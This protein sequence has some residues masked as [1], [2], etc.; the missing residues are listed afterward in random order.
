VQALQVQAQVCVR[1]CVCLLSTTSAYDIS[2]A[3]Q[4]GI[5]TF[6]F[7][8]CR[9]LSAKEPLII[10]LFCEKQPAKMRPPMS[11]SKAIQSGVDA[12]V[13]YVKLQVSFRQRATNHRALLR[14]TAM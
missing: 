11:I 3:I 7:L 1:V 5:E 14:K 4:G 10:G 9:S 2:E 6:D 8:S 13:G 12:W